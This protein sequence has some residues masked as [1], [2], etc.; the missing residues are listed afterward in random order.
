M[1]DTQ[2]QPQGETHFGFKTVR[3]EEKASLVREVFDS[4]APKYDLMNDLMSAGIHRLWKASFLDWLR[5]RPDQTLLDV[6]GGTGDIA[7]G[8][9]KRGGG[10]ALVCDINK[11]MLAVGRDRSF[12]RNL[13]GELAWVCGNAECLPVADRSVDRYTIAFCLRNVTHWENAIA[14]AYRVLKPGGRFM[15]LEFSRVVLPGLREAYDMYSFNLLPRIGE[16]VT[17]NRE[18]YQYLVESIR[19]FPAPERFAGLI[20]DAGFAGVR[21]RPLSGGIAALHAGYRV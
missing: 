20:R 14:E 6:G 15:C 10:P 2:N 5:P 4:V 1:T 3:E 8:W 17:G 13:V 21:W 16:M 7:F 9:K 18:A 12:D 19:R 11:E